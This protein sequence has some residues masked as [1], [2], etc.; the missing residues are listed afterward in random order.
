MRSAYIFGLTFVF[1]LIISFNIYD[2]N[3]DIVCD[4]NLPEIWFVS[5]RYYEK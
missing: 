1:L 3:F 5:T 4:L 2:C